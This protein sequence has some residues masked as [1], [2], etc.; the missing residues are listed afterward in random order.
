MQVDVRYLVVHFASYL[1]PLHGSIIMLLLQ[2]VMIWTSSQYN[3]Y[4]VTRPILC[5]TNGYNVTMCRQCD[6]RVPTPCSPPPSPSCSA[7]PAPASAAGTTT[8]SRGR[9]RAAAA[10]PRPGRSRPAPAST[11]TPRAGSTSPSSW[12]PRTSVLQF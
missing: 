9:R 11:P 3:T 8:S 1:S 10:G 7:S 2:L 12:S 6:T 4:S 5:T